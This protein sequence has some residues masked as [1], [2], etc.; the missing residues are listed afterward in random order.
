MIHQVTNSMLKRICSD[1]GAVTSGIIQTLFGWTP[2]GARRKVSQQ[3]FRAAV[4]YRVMKSKWSRL[5]ESNLPSCLVAFKL[6]HTAVRLFHLVYDSNVS[7]LQKSC[8]LQISTLCAAGIEPA[9]RTERQALYHELIVK[10]III[11]QSSP[12]RVK[13]RFITRW[14]FVSLISHCQAYE[15]DLLV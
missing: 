9:Y 11:L 8:Q 3:A 13:C 10:M 5:Q 12:Q 7:S 4:P 6:I 1:T 2:S 15:C 14:D